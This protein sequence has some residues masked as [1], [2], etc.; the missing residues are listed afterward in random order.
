MLRMQA[1][2]EMRAGGLEPLEPVEDEEIEEERID[3]EEDEGEDLMEN[4]ER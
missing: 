4:M 2:E 1:D 3:D